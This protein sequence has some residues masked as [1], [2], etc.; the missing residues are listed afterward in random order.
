[1][2]SLDQNYAS[3]KS[4]NKKFDCS[5]ARFIATMASLNTFIPWSVY[6]AIFWFLSILDTIF[7]RRSM[8]FFHWGINR[9]SFESIKGF[10]INLSLG[11]RIFE[12]YGCRI[13][14]IR[15]SYWYLKALWCNNSMGEVLIFLEFFLKNRIL[16]LIFSVEHN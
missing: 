15:F 13:C 4:T 16:N 14:F 7:H 10:I 8:I 2:A 5:K 12:V 3:Q 9:M 6:M 11:S 1:M